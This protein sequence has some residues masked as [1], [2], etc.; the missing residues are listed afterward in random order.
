MK[1]LSMSKPSGAL[2]LMLVVAL[3]GLVLAVFMPRQPHG[4]AAPS[5]QSPADP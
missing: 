4:T 3:A 5:G 2:A 1:C